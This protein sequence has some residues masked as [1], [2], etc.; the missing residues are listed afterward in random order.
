M[1]LFPAQKDGKLGF[2]DSNGTEA[3]PFRYR[4]AYGFSEGV[5]WAATDRKFGLID[6][7]GN[8][9]SEP[10]WDDVRNFRCGRAGV[11]IVRKWGIIDREGNVLLEPTY[12]RF[13]DYAEDLACVH[14]SRTNDYSTAYLNLSG[15]VALGPFPHDGGKSFS[16]GLARISDGDWHRYIDR[17]GKVQLELPFIRNKAVKNRLKIDAAGDFSCGLA[18]V[19]NAKGLSGYIDK[20]GE[21]KIDFRFG[22]ADPFSEGLAHVCVDGKYGYINTTG[23][24]VI[25][26][27]FDLA[28][29]FS[30]GL[31][32]VMVGDLWGVI[33]TAGEFVMKPQ[34]DVFIDPF[35]NG[36]AMVTHEKDEN[37]HLSGYINARGEIV[38]PLT[39]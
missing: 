17:Q 28:E 25:K 11:R 6:T 7:R 39:C 1:P 3:I 26:P 32:S 16:D 10:R 15:A 31:A 29:R 30:E 38:W 9:V 22:M 37:D 27:A 2:I 19:S 34:F 14:T 21:V 36:L 20:S 18:P 33:N 12:E 23:D 24:F 8:A 35:E 13:D 5:A 4:S